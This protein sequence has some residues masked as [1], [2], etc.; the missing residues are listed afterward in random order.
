MSSHKNRYKN[1]S[2]DSQELRRRREE[3]GIQLR[4]QKRENALC[5]RRNLKDASVMEEATSTTNEPKVDIDSIPLLTEDILSGIE[6]RE[7]SAV[8]IFRKLLSKEPDP[9][10]DHVISTGVVPKFVEFLRRPNSVLQFEAAWALTNIASG[11][12]SQTKCVIQTGAVP[13]FIELLKCDNEDVTEQCIWALGNIAGDSTECRDF[14]LGLGIMQPLTEV[15]SKSTKLS[16]LRN[17]V[18]VLSNLCRGKNPPPSFQQVQP[19]LPVLGR[20]L[21]HND[22]DIL[23]DTCWALSYISDGPNDRIQAVINVGVARRLVELLTNEKQSVV[24]AALRAV[25]NIVTGDDTQTQIILNCNALP[26]LLTLLSSSKDSIRKEACWTISNITAGSREQIQD[27]IQ[28]NIFPKL[29][30]ILSNSDYK[31]RKEAAW[32]I[33]N[34]VSGGNPAQIKYIVECNCIQPL[35]EL[36]TVS[37]PKIIQVAL[38]ALENILKVGE[39]FCKN[40]E[41]KEN[42]Y[43]IA[44]EECN[45]LDQIEY[46]QSHENIEIYNKAF[47][48]IDT[49]FSNDEEQATIAP[50]VDETNQQFRFGAP[51][52]V[53]PQ[54][55]DGGNNQFN[56]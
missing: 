16:M 55:Q 48:I 27:I 13:I 18:W 43:A 52:N 14:V 56:F 3:E 4:K 25:G 7:L 5:K 50:N 31:S 39:L 28:E 46:L 54:P 12:S 35:C 9:P 15:L 40:G 45:G 17:A 10:I 47:E 41:C 21:F 2:L 11:N 6:E 44:I 30:E 42:P 22:P 8:Q 32:A 49:Y 36:L 53:G 1:Y 24:A 29:I 51:S 20:L 34:A 26:H 37:D 23:T 19:C 33:S 38:G